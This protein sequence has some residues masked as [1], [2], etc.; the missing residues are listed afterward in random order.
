MTRSDP[1]PPMEKLPDYYRVLGVPANASTEAICD[2]YRRLARVHHPSQGGKQAELVKL[3]EAF[4]MLR[5]GLS[6]HWYDQARAKP[7]D[8]RLEADL[9][10]L[11]RREAGRAATYPENY[12]RF[13]A[14]VELDCSLAIG[15]LP[16]NLAG[17]LGAIAGT[18]A[19]K[20]MLAV[21]KRRW[22]RPAWLDEEAK[23]QAESPPPPTRK[24][25]RRKRTKG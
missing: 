18:I 4:W 7:G 14:A 23:A 5:G 16:G 11:A 24:P 20:A 9:R 21:E 1:L 8:E 15:G 6:R 17:S 12:K 22:W 25:P 2:A 3:V 19:G 13:L 10:I